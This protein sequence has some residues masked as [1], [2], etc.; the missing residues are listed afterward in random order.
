MQGSQDIEKINKP[1]KHN[2]RARNKKRDRRREEA[3]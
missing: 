1:T 3:T 2:R